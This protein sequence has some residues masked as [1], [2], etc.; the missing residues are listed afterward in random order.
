[1]AEGD[2]LGEEELDLVERAKMGVPIR[3][4]RYTKLF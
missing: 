3:K 1:M 4:R 2:L